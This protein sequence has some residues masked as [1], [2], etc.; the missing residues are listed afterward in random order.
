MIRGKVVREAK[1]A[2]EPEALVAVLT[3]PTYS[4]KR[5]GLEAELE[6]VMPITGKN[7]F[8]NDIDECV[9]GTGSPEGTLR[10]VNVVGP[11]IAIWFGRY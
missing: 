7:T 1:I 8:K 10:Q 11:K 4:F 9:H 3:N 2:S 6:R 5:I